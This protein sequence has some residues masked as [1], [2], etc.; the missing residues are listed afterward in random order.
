MRRALRGESGTIVALDYR[1]VE[2]LA[3]YEKLRGLG[4]GAVAKIDIAE[5]RRPFVRAGLLVSGIALCAIAVGVAFILRTTSPL[6]RKIEARN[7]E[8]RAAHQRLRIHSSEASLAVER[9]RRRLAV[10]LHDGL[11]QLLALAKIKLGLVREKTDVG[12]F[13]ARLHEIEGLIVE[14]R[15]QTR[16]LTSQLCPPVLY[17]VGLVAALRWLAEE[18]ERRYGLCVS[19]E[20]EGECPGLDETVRIS[21]FRGVSE[22]LINVA[23]HASTDKARVRVLDAGPQAELAISVEDQGVGFDSSSGSAGYGLFSLR[24]RLHHLGGSMTIASTPGA[25]T[26]VSIRAP[27]S[28]PAAEPA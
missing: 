27:R 10:D 3:A 12:E 16:A 9:E 2:V 15:Q 18:M 7:Q 14:A 11:G 26:V 19:I 28:A 17:E 1:G 8:L 5:I 6:I 24:E 4:W 21:L 20:A 25:G 22:L 13:A 23:R